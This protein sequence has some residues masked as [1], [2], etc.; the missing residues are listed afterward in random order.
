MNYKD[1][2]KVNIVGLLSE[3]NVEQR[4]KDG[5]KYVTGNIK[6]QITP[7]N[8]IPINVFAFE[9]TKA[10]TKNP[11]YTQIMSVCDKGI[12]LAACGGDVTKATKVRANTCRF[13]ENMFASRF[14]GNIISST[15][16]TGSFFTLGASEDP[17]AVFTCGIN[18]RSIKEEVNSGGEETGR[19]LVEG[20]IEQYNRW[21]I[22]TFI[23]ESQQAVDYIRANWEKGD[24]VSISGRIVGKTITQTVSSGNEGGFGEPEEETRFHTK[25]PEND[26]LHYRSVRNLP[27]SIS[28]DRQ[29]TAAG[30]RHAYF[31]GRLAAVAADAGQDGQ[32]TDRKGRKQSLHQ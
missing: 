5:R 8:V 22:L 17:K 32:H 4:E 9:N 30:I 24:T 10:G 25:S 13:E 23:A 12:S 29:R 11:A 31:P 27:G 21:D 3:N 1:N 14:N 15:R 7:E 2:N 18:I 28:S 20:A 26:S 19:L 6:I 16:V